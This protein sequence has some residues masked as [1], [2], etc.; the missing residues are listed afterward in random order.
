MTVHA[1][2]NY[3]TSGRLLQVGGCDGDVYTGPPLLACGV[4]RER[5]YDEVRKET[6][7]RSEVP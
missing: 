3:S 7:K 6:S 2:C 5:V 1:S 4:R